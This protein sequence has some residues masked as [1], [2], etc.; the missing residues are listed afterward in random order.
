[1]AFEKVLNH[2]LTVGS[3]KSGFASL[4]T[5]GANSQAAR[6]NQHHDSENGGA[7]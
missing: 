3:F 7:N 6:Q 5:L 1:M 2:K 4:P